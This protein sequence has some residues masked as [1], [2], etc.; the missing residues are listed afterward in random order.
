MDAGTARPD[1]PTSPS[2]IT[3]RAL[4]YQSRT[5][6]RLPAK[7][8]RNR[9]GHARLQAYTTDD[10]SSLHS[11][12]RLNN[13]KAATLRVMAF[14]ITVVQDFSVL[15]ARGQ[16]WN[17]LVE[18]AETGTIFQT[19]EMHASWWNAFGNTGRPLVML[20]IERG[21][22]F[23]IAPLM[24][25]DQI[26][27]GHARRVVQF[28]GARSFDYCDFIID[29]ARP[30][31]LPLLL[32]NLA[33]R[34]TFDLL[35]LRDIPDTS[36]TVGRLR[37]YFEGRGLPVD[38]R[39]LYDAPTLLL[40][41]PV[42]DRRLANKKSLKRHYNY[43]HKAGRLQFK[44][45]ATADEIFEYLDVFFEQHIKRRAVTDIPSTFHDEAMR[46]FFRELVRTLTP[47]GWLLF[48]VVLFNEKPIAM[49][50]GFEYGDR[51]IW[52]KPTFDIGY[53]NHSPGEVLMKYLLEY[54]LE[55]GVR[56]LDFTIGA[57]PFKYRFANHTRSNSAVRVFRNSLPYRITR[58][59]LD[60]EDFVRTSPALSRI[61]RRAL[62]RWRGKA[63][64]L[65]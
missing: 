5:I 50:F 28:I 54:A 53:A 23:G 6:W 10:L 16:E 21:K 35:Y 12:E 46:A 38:V 44:T 2:A 48:S 62:G 26:V 36:T 55:R 14:E 22:L 29:R 60:V 9:F 59:M 49:H 25:S 47:K 65:R 56:E 8:L 58:M 19:Y 32:A 40:K 33:Y 39:A 42:A 41:D 63:W 4:R 13:E 57:E 17:A 34:K 37:N 1:G 7:S 30:D 45:C 15:E 51:I 11:R 24:I 18:R 27:L 3:P 43:F 31:V 61:A 64:V 52:Y 20:A